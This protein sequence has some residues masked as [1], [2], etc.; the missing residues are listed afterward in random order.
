MKKSTG[1]NDK[2]RKKS[3]GGETGFEPNVSSGAVV[4]TNNPMRIPKYAPNKKHLYVGL[5]IPSQMIEDAL[6]WCKDHLLIPSSHLKNKKKEFLFDECADS[7]SRNQKGMMTMNSMF[8]NTYSSNVDWGKDE[9]RYEITS[10]IVGNM[11]SFRT[12]VQ[13]LVKAAER[14]ISHVIN[15][16]WVVVKSSILYSRAGGNPQGW[17]ID[18]SRDMS[19]DEK[20]KDVM[21]SEGP[22][23]SAIISLMPGTKIEFLYKNPF[24]ALHINPGHMVVFD[25]S[26]M[27]R[28]CAYEENNVRLHLYLAK[29]SID[30]R[31]EFDSTVGIWKC[32]ICA[33]KDEPVWYV[34]PIT[35]TFQKHL[36]RNH[37]DIKMTFNKYKKLYLEEE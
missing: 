11:R 30:T 26:A 16:D 15:E 7:T 4:S 29:R 28:G 10:L 23:G 24:E 37:S 22:I 12:K 18:D 35:K 36:I 5:C 3:V 33:A 2:K 27:H 19:T 14:F 21:E 1:K 8:S 6:E 31:P 13:P 9:N 17:H 32:E 20:F 34:T 25:G